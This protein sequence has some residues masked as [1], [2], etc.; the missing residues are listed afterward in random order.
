MK[1]NKPVIIVGIIVI[2]V[3]ILIFS[4]A[5]LLGN[6]IENELKKRQMGTFNVQS[7]EAD[8]NILLRR[9]TIKDVVAE[10]STGNQKFIVPEIQA[11]GIHIFPFV[12]NDKVIINKLHIQNPVINLMQEKS[13]DKDQKT[14]KPG[15]ENDRPIELIR[16][17]QLEIADAEVLIQKQ[18]SDNSDTLLTLHAGLNLW[19]LNIFND[20]EQLTF[21]KHSAEKLQVNINNVRYDLPGELYRLQFDSLNYSSEEEALSL[22]DLYFSSVHS[23][24]D[25]AKQTG[26]ETDW[27]D[28]VLKQFEMKGINL[29]ALL[30]DTVVVF[31]KA[32]LNEL[33]AT[34]F[35]D[36]RPPFPDKPDTKLPMEMLKSLPFALHSD[37]ILIKNASVVYEEH[38]EEST[39]TGTVTF[40]RLY[41]SI[42]NL[43]TIQDSING[44]TAMSARAF[45]MNESLLLL[46]FVFP[47]NK[48]SLQYQVSG[49]LEPVQL[50][51]FN[52]MLVPAAF[53]RVEE[54]RIK[55]M[56]FDFTYDE[57]KSEG[58]L[59]L[60]YEN[61][62]ISLLDKDD[63]SQKK[64]KTFITET[65][66]L[67]KENLKE[68]NSYQ[69]GTISAQREKK[70]SIFNYWWK[71]IFSGIKD[72][73][74]F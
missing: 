63:G 68:K 23:K 11:T 15:T 48:Y 31:R 34:I 44:Q 59:S 32:V 50:T 39:E 22:V 51:A 58:S 8:V 9:V 54:G 57:N 4:G 42:Y 41:A 55:S 3:L 52:P 33:T 43:G 67:S 1:K 27:Y 70:K 56:N 24:Y 45:I 61:L 7:R 74:A 71:S 6:Y 17:K 13:D 66:V 72:V 53:V 60:E 38:A 49:S 46:E 73:L 64:I 14:E 10:D 40:N 2:A 21:G 12:F 36:K 30:K 65:F 28:I 62:D 37:S 5:V 26:V 20:R 19:N 69:E 16:I 25:I 18:S 29:D 47:N 35:R